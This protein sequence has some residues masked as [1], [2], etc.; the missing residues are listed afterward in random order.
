MTQDNLHE[1]AVGVDLV[2]VAPI[3]PFQAP[4]FRLKLFLFVIM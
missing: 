1:A 2:S 4:L 3:S